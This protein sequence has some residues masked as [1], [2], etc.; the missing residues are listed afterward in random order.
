MTV[1]IA[2]A[3][4]I[5]AL[6][7]QPFLR[8]S[9]AFDESQID[10]ALQALRHQ[11]PAIIAVERA[12]AA[13]RTGQ[14]LL[15]Q[16]RADRSLATCQI[17]LVGARQAQRFRLNEPVTLDGNAATLLDISSAG[18][19]IVGP[20]PLKAAQAIVLGLRGGRPPLPAQTVWVQY[21]LPTEGPRYRAGIRFTN[22]GDPALA[23]FISAMTR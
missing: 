22:P 21:E 10:A 13:S 4:A 6:R 16:I 23:D 18:A 8:E 2:P 5:S 11:V 3:E 14:E 15:E 7:H 1:L 20:A 12:L 19:R 9:V 17:Q